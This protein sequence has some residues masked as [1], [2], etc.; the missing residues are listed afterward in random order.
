MPSNCLLNKMLFRCNL[1]PS[2]LY[3]PCT[4][5]AL[6]CIVPAWFLS[7]VVVLNLALLSPFSKGVPWRWWVRLLAH[8]W[9]QVPVVA[10]V[11]ALA[12]SS[13][14][15][16][17]VLGPCCPCNKSI[18]FTLQ[19]VN[20]VNYQLGHVYLASWDKELCTHKW[21]IVFYFPSV[22]KCHHLLL[23]RYLEIAR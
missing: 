8:T 1:T 11:S 20:Y 13:S 23:A 10:H 17:A 21:N 6:F 7:T 12:A 15:I 4:S 18:V 5:L 2:Y 19:L 3:N 22:T 14:F 16:F 9:R